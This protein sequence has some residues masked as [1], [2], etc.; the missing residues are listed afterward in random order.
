MGSPEPVAIGFALAQMGVTDDE[1]DEADTLESI[2]LAER[3]EGKQMPN[4]TAQSNE[5][6][7]ASLGS[8][9]LTSIMNGESRIGSD[10]LKHALVEKS[11]VDRKE[12]AESEKKQKEQEAK[13]AALKKEAEKAA[14]AEQNQHF[15]ADD[16][17]HEE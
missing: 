4:P 9:S 8:T 5:A 2:K 11:E 12:R 7:T 3:I 13:N 1:V 16:L 10:I 14:L 17:F 15:A 6:R